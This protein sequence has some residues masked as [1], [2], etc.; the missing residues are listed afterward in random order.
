MYQNT[1]KPTEKEDEPKEDE[2]EDKSKEVEQKEKPYVPPPP[3]KPLI[4]YPQWLAKSKSVWKFKKNIEVLKQ[5]NI[6]IA[7]TEVISQMLSYAKFLKEILSNKKKL[8]D[9]EIGMIIAEC[10]AII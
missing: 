7:F 2:K 1:G 9:S 4:S 3:Y 5:L 6:T 10:S 8:E